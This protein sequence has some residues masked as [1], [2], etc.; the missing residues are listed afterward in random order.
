[1]YTSAAMKAI[2][3]VITHKGRNPKNNVNRNISKPPKSNHRKPPG[4]SGGINVSAAEKIS[5]PRL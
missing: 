1:M 4:Q 3:N 2:Q 5:P